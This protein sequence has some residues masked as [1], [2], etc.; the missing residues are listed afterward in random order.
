MAVNREQKSTQTAA[1]A[2][3]LEKALV[4]AFRESAL[5]G[6]N[7][8]F[9]Q[10]A[11][12]EAA[13]FTLRC[14]LNREDSKANLSLESVSG[15]QNHRHLRLAI[16]NDDMPFLVDSVCATIAGFGLT[17]ERLIHPVVAVRRDASG[18]L[19]QINEQAEG[20]GNRESVIYIELERTDARI[21]R[22]L[23]KA[24]RAKER[25]PPCCDGSLTATSHCWATKSSIQR[26]S[27]TGNWALPGCGRNQS[28]PKKA[29]DARSNGLKR[30]GKPR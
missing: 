26:A 4:A 2:A 15:P 24:L 22:E 17:I 29:G 1:D 7:I 9:D 19:I 8:G 14:A 25:V 6:E 12:E 23:V 28:F 18:Q 16:V 11:C 13:R 20:G 30:L 27:V 5:P 21:R 10:N 3:G